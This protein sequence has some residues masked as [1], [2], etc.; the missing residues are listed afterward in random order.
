M[1]KFPDKTAMAEASHL[2]AFPPL[3]DNVQKNPAPKPE[4]KWSLGS[5][6]VF[7]N[8]PWVLAD[9]LG[10][11]FPWTQDLHGV[12]VDINFRG[13]FQKKKNPTY[14]QSTKLCC[15]SDT[16]LSTLQEM[17]K[18]HPSTRTRLYPHGPIRFQ[19]SEKIPLWGILEKLMYYSSPSQK[20][21]LGNANRT[22][23]FPLPW[24]TTQIFHQGPISSG[25]FPLKWMTRELSEMLYKTGKRNELWWC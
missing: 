10:L 8:S 13:Q 2:A 23:Q 17:R 6:P 18:L 1:G 20:E 7:I 19:H 3:I 15:S 16:A 5:E 25:W 11:E 22:M 14:S 21:H 12:P 9:L 24:K 4:T